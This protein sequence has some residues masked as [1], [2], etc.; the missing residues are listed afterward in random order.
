MHLSLRRHWPVVVLS[1]VIGTSV[2]LAGSYFY[3][4]SRDIMESQLK[5]QLAS[6]AG[7]AA[8]FI[9]GDELDQIQGPKDETKPAFIDLVHR[10][11]S[12][13]TLP[14]VR[15]AYIMRKTINPMELAFVA[16]ADALSTK[17]ELDVNHD[18]VVSPDEAP[19]HP[20]DLYD[21]SNVPALQHDAFL[22]PTTDSTV[23]YDQWGALISGYAPIYR[24][25]GSVAGIIG[26]DMRADLYA[27][28]SQSIFTPVALVLVVLGGIL[29]AVAI[30]TL[31]ERRQ[32]MILNKINNERSGLLKLTFHQ[33]GEPLT[34]MKWSL[35]TL[36]DS[37]D[38]PRLQAIVEEHVVCM[39]EGLGR[40]NSI[41]DTLQQAEKVDL[42]TLDYLPVPSSL[43][44]LFENSVHEWQSSIDKRKQKMNV[45][46]D[47][48]LFFPF[49]HNML[50]LVLR[51]LLQNAIEYS[52]EG[53]TITLRA[54][55]GK[56]R[57]T[58]SI[59]D[60][61]VGIPREDLEH[62]FEKYRRASNAGR[63]KPDG[64]GLGLYIAKGIVE[65]AGGRIWIESIEGRGTKISFTLPIM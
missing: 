48:D 32:L 54:S 47:K 14:D 42:N 9:P 8:L 23:T 16:D 45:V 44:N 10:L 43:K 15:F 24:K 37:V 60:Q 61:G 62:M 17:A 21:I 26:I 27:F 57:V 19:S 1:I 50:S 30:V 41:I 36:R 53:S 65:K 18:G 4:R 12:L 7:S 11:K 6:M 34:I 55:E 22:H 38:D 28:L 56:Q 2:A 46:M 29:I 58:I 35:E 59:E 20:G 13:R 49:D 3:I 63:V 25:D 39:D 33:L 51:Q 5:T 52:P 64:N 31:W 40:L